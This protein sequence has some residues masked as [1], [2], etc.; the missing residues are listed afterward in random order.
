MQRLAL[1]QLARARGIWRATAAG[2]IAE[3]ILCRRH[4]TCFETAPY[5]KI[6]NK[7]SCGAHRPSPRDRARLSPPSRMGDEAHI[8]GLASDMAGVL[9]MLLLITCGLLASFC[10][11]IYMLLRRAFRALVR[12]QQSRQVHARYESVMQLP[13]RK[14]TAADAAGGDRCCA[15]CLES[16]VAGDRLRSLPCGHSFHVGC[17]DPWLLRVAPKALPS[18]PLCKASVQDPPSASSLGARRRVTAQ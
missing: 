14:A 17:I 4:H 18:C 11:C 1:P 16:I 15:I 12:W 7:N 8:N 6:I 5:T 10:A 9:P 3:V 2:R 13:V